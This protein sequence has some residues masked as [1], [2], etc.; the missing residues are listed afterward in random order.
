NNQLN[1]LQAKDGVTPMYNRPVTVEVW[2]P[3]I[4]PKG[5]TALTTYT[6]VLGSLRDSTRPLKPFQ[7]YGRSLRDAAPLVS[8]A[9]Y[10]L[11][12]VSHGFPGS[13]VL[14]TYLTEN[15]ASKGYVVVA[16]DHAE[17][18]HADA[19]GFASTLLNRAPDILFVLN[20]V[21]SLGKTGHQFLEGLANANN[22]ALIGYSM[23][24]YGVLNVAGAGYSSKL[25]GFFGTIAGGSKAIDSRLSSAPGFSG[26]VDKRIKAVVAFAP[27]GMEMGVWDSTGLQALRI[28]TLFV[29][30]SQDDVSGYEKGTKAIFN[31]AINANRYL[32]TYENARHNTAPN[33]PPPESMQSGKMAD[34]YH[35][36]EPAWNER[37][38]NNI[39]QHFVTAFLGL[40]LKQQNMGEY[41]TLPPNSNQQKWPG[42][43]KRTVTG[44]Q[45]QHLQPAQ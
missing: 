24:G 1:I 28:P 4:I 32:L 5:K 16:I 21:A 10:P 19:A 29:A 23:G 40:Y 37:K 6:D 25:A 17:S 3:A 44:V 26:N 22:T 33:P 11:V 41:L 43:E 7:F 8:S 42:F 15:L 2:Y 36:A 30:G 38:I 18:T 35:Y 27:W 39:N 9:P 31:G 45:W 34:Y 14:L 13:R 20:Q 12:I